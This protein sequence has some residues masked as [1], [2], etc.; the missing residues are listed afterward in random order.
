MKQ[1]IIFF[2]FFLNVVNLYSQNKIALVVGVSKYPK[3]SEW[4]AIN[5]LND[6][7]L[8]NPSLK[9]KGF[10]TIILENEQA[11]KKNIISKIK[12]IERLALRGDII[13]IHF[14]THGQQMIDNNS[15]EI[16][17]LDEAIIPYDAKK[18]YCENKYEGG[19]H[20]R[21]DELNNLLNN[22]RVKIGEDG[23]LI[24][25]ADACHSATITRGEQV[26]D[27]PS[28]G[29][30][31]IFGNKQF[32]PSQNRKTINT[33]KYIYKPIEKNKSNFTVISACQDYQQN[34]EIKVNNIYY[35]V[36]SYS[37]FDVLENK[38]VF[39]PKTFH[40]DIEYTI[41]KYTSKQ[42]P[43]IETTFRN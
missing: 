15:D 36:L 5:G 14:S 37:I 26:N 19:N 30:S 42:M 22:I 27:N 35:G 38:L 39:N 18:Y 31:I 2:C 25:T 11:T 10:K 9:K 34:F 17:K 33:E 21:D 41:K 16:D 43:K 4:S 3:S 29:T 8:L 13:L 1:L 12:E 28:R 7:K 6:I 23:T 24:I 40:K 20:L 32:L